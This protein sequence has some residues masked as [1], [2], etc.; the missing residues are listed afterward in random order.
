M[1]AKERRLPIWL[2]RLA[3]SLII[4]YLRVTPFRTGQR[5]L[6]RFCR[7]HL[8][9][10]LPPF[11]AIVPLREAPSISIQC[12][13]LGNKH[14]ADILSEWL[15]LTGAWQPALTAYLRRALLP[16]DTLVDVGAN[17]G[18]FSLLGAT[19]VGAT[20][21]VV[22]VE[23]CPRTYE[24]LLANLA[25]N[26]K[27]AAAVT[28]VHAAAAETEGELTLYQH[29]REPLYNT[30][31]AGACAGG[32]AAAADVWALLQSCG[33]LGAAGVARG[34]AAAEEVS[35]LAVSS[36]WQTTRVRGAPLDALLSE[37]QLRKARVLKVDV[38][39]AEWAVLQGARRLLSS[40]DDDDDWGGGGSTGAP[41]LEVVVEV[42]P[43]WLALQQSSVKRLFEHMRALGYNAYLLPAD[44]YEISVALPMARA[45]PPP[46]RRLRRAACAT[47]DG[48]STA[49]RTPIGRRTSSSA[50]ATL[51]SS[52]SIIVNTNEIIKGGSSGRA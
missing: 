5:T 11:S 9:S 34:A 45:P 10:R 35:R 6:L 41:T 42:T 8:L 4:R 48:S 50:G 24:R 20:G 22:A 19:L 46:P 52:T 14:H 21:S 51:S 49:A 17:T 29:R 44:D 1:A 12:F 3:L 16:G 43:K 25:L 18:Y 32:V 28:P 33:A 26:P 2:L 27:L 31:V 39:G 40:A 13:Q 37:A 15:L 7:S 23:A 47:R 30:T 36:V 38:E